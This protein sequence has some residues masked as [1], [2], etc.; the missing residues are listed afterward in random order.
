[1]A[2]ATAIGRDTMC[3]PQLIFILDNGVSRG[4]MVSEA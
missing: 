1:V 4:A 2:V 3:S